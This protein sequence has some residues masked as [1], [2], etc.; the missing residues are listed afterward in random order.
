MPRPAPL[1]LSAENLPQSIRRFC[2][3]AAPQ[4][5][6]LMAA[7]GMVPVKGEEQVMIL[8]QLSSDPDAAL[9]KAAEQSLHKLPEGVLLPACQVALNPSFLD[10][11][12]ELFVIRDD[13]IERVVANPATDSASIEWVAQRCS[14]KVSERI[15]INEQRLLAA[16]GIIEALYRNKNTRMSTAD[17][18]IELAARNDVK[19]DIPTFQ[20]HVDA[21]KGQLIP[22]PTEEPLPTDIA[23][24]QVLAEDTD[25]VEG[26]VAT[27]EETAEEEVAK[28][29]LPLMMRVRTMSSSE[30]IRLALVGSGA[31]RA[32]LVRDKNKTVAYAAITSPA[33]GEN[34]IPPIAR[35]KEVSEEVLRYVGNKREWTKNYEIK[36]GLLF[37]PKCPVG[38]ALRFVPH[39][40]DGDLKELSRTRNVAQPIKSAA[41]Q[42]IQTKEKK[43][44][45][46]K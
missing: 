20:A 33:I 44:K 19:L 4:P 42:R 41:L 46:G 2:D 31:A 30:K 36:L 28:K 37:N 27:N 9:S 7:R 12:L 23:F 3:P 1:P 34:E 39:L 13:V 16:P 38:I 11:L 25:E 29:F 22:E 6:R 40:R 14:E 45:G 32:F 17:R 26:V 21:I 15:A 35:S 5:A 8:L 18:L 24:S 43:E 10:R